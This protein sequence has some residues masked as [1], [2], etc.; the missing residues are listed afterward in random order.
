M[1]ST[2]CFENVGFGTS[3]G[4]AESTDRPLFNNSLPSADYLQRVRPAGPVALSAVIMQLKLS[5]L[6]RTI[7][8]SINK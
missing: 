2:I 1:T 4:G 7:I 3:E 8:I 6:L 5:E